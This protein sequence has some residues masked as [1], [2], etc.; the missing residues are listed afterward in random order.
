M[1][2]SSSSFNRKLIHSRFRPVMTF[3]E[4]NIDRG[5]FT[6]VSF[7]VSNGSVNLGSEIFLVVK[8]L[9]DAQNLSYSGLKFYLWLL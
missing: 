8:I 1:D 6:S 2:G 9:T 4:A 3:S 7:S 5:F